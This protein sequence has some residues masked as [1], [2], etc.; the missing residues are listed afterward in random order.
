M[1]KEPPLVGG[2]MTRTE[3]HELNLHGIQTAGCAECCDNARRM[4][5]AHDKY[6]P[7][8]PL[9]A[10]TQWRFSQL[11]PDPRCPHRF[12]CPAHYKIAGGINDL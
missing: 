9:D 8:L 5:E 12:L 4:R 1:T 11:K 6:Y 10:K 3:A 7:D 2:P